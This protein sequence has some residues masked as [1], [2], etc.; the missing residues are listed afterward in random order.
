MTLR[1]KAAA[2][3]AD[4]VSTERE[5][6]PLRLGK[7]M[8]SVVVLI[9]IRGKDPGNDNGAHAGNGQGAEARSVEHAQNNSTICASMAETCGQTV[10]IS[11]NNYINAE[12]GTVSTLWQAGLPCRLET[13][14]RT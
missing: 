13:Q 9:T 4:Y 3:V 1:A 8:E 10:Q 5:K 11:A 7:E 14:R 2:A 6:I 12:T